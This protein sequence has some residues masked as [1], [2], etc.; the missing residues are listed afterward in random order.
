VTPI[1]GPTKAT[2]STHPWSFTVTDVAKFLGKSPVTLRKWEHLGLVLF[3]RVGHERR[4]STDDLRE[5]SQW[6]FDT[7]RIS[8][9]RLQ[10]IDAAATMLDLLEEKR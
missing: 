5:L 7:G 6:A 1:D 3:P 8:K 10:L 2:A 4:A 9:K